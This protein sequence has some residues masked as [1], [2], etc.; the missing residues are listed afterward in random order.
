LPFVSLVDA[1]ILGSVVSPD[2]KQATKREHTPRPIPER[3][4]VAAAEPAASSAEASP[5]PV[6]NPRRRRLPTAPAAERARVGG[7]P[8]RRSEG[9]RGGGP[10]RRGPGRRGP[11]AAAAHSAGDG[12]SGACCPPLNTWRWSL[13][14][15]HASSP[16]FSPRRLLIL[17]GFLMGTSSSN[18][19]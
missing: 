3:V 4:H 17:I 18:A 1:C 6:C 16:R 12:R 2:V 19:P 9:P 11:A 10:Q 5:F 8:Q 7:C 13:Q 15:R 14:R